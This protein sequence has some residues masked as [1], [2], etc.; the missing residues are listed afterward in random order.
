MNERQQRIQ[1]ENEIEGYKEELKES[2][3][4]ILELRYLSQNYHLYSKVNEYFYEKLG[5]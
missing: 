1:Y 5:A 3:K 2:Y 4:V